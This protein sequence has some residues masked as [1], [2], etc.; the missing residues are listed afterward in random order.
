MKLS[1]RYKAI[2]LIKP[3]T[4]TSTVTG[5]AVDTLGYNDDILVTLSLGAA[6][7]TTETCIVTIQTDDNDS[8]SSATT[9]VTFGTLTGTSDNK[10]ACAGFTMPIGDRYVRAVA[11]IAGST[12]SFDIC[13]MALVQAEAQGST[14]N[15]TTAA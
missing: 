5:S 2:T 13:I 6:L 14:I 3:Q 7:T 1:E 4:A 11:T 10:T 8:F 9:Q 15:S 12:P